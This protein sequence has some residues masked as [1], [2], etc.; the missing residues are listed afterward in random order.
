MP[1]TLGA[2]AMYLLYLYQSQLMVYPS[3][4]PLHA[5]SLFFPHSTTFNSSLFTR[6]EERSWNPYLFFCAPTLKNHWPIGT[7]AWWK[8]QASHVAET[9]P[10]S[11]RASVQRAAPRKLWL[12]NMPYGYPL[13]LTRCSKEVDT[14][15]WPVFTEATLIQWLCSLA[16]H[17]CRWHGFHEHC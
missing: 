9:G 2:K 13:Q 17:R 4:L 16:L 7:M 14:A 6:W 3:V 1:E 15:L 11:L 12:H 5:C 10:E 8:G